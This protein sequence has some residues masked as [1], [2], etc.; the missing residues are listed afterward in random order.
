MEDLKAAQLSSWGLDLA[1]RWNS[2]SY[3]VFVLHGNIFDLYPTP[4]QKLSYQS[5]KGHL[6]RRFF[7]NR[8]CVI[9]YDISDGVSFLTEEMKEDFFKWL[10][11]GEKL[12]HRFRT[13]NISKIF[14]EIAPIL[15][16]YFYYLNIQTTKKYKDGRNG[17]TI[18]IEFPEKIFPSAEDSN[19]NIEERMSVV[20][21]LKWA[22]S[23]ELRRLDVGVFLL[24]ETLSELQADIIRNPNIA[25]IRVEMP[26]VEIRKEFIES[27]WVKQMVGGKTIE[28]WSDLTA[29]EMAVRCA[30]LNLV[31]IKQVINEA[32]HNEKIVTSAHIA[33]SKKR[34]IEEYCQGLVSLME[35]NKKYSLESVAN[36]EAKKKKLKELAWLIK[37]GKTDVLEKGVLL[38]GRIGVGKSFIVKCF[39]SE[40][41]LPVM[42]IGEFRSKWVGDTESQLARILITIRALGPVIVVVDEAATVFGNQGSSNDSGVSSRV[43]SAFANHIGD[44]SLRGREPWIAMTPRPDLMA[45]DMKRQGRF[46]LCIPLFPTRNPEE[47]S[48]LFNTCSKVQKLTLDNSIIEFVKLKFGDREL[49]GSDVESILV[50]SRERAVLSGREKEVSIEDI[51]VAI[52]SFIDPLDPNTLR[53]QEL[54]ALL[55]CSDRR[56][57]SDKYQTALSEN[58]QALVNEFAALKRI[59]GDI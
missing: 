45:I 56:F 28:Q 27:A 20:A 39:A 3:S 11:L 4:D 46:G 26:D 51:Q 59:L 12:G 25:Q 41:E 58:K 34:L 48:I 23:A 47:V 29:Q 30:G 2:N 18:I 42:V 55:A 1:I 37:N 36:H 52:D 54:A 22:V 33:V 21:L 7:P 49:T 8:E 57:L 16:E 14:I 24:A 38:P 32:I 43:F 44:D 17:A 31:R 5:L 13:S 50:R 40:C 9:F 10:S 15:K 35:P 53:L 19:S 6:A